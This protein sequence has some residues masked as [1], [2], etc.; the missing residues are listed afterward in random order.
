[1]EVRSWRA[2][3]VGDAGRDESWVGG[4]SDDDG[5]VEAATLVV[6]RVIQRVTI[7]GPRACS[8]TELSS[9]LSVSSPFCTKVMFGM[10]TCGR[11][12]DVCRA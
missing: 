2:V 1:M 12:P 4:V 8:R 3:E 6:V 9:S 7:S 5:G 11:T 10:S